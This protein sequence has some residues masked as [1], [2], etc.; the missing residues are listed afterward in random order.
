M[1]LLSRKNGRPFLTP[2]FLSTYQTVQWSSGG[3]NIIPSTYIHTHLVFPCSIISMM[4]HYLVFG[5]SVFSNWLTSTSKYRFL[6]FLPPCLPCFSFQIYTATLTGTEKR[7]CSRE[8]CLFRAMMAAW[9]WFHRG[10]PVLCV[11]IWH[12]F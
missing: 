9:R 12:S 10:G 5:I 2:P 11:N 1:C 3:C 6:F 7:E 4:L 8:A